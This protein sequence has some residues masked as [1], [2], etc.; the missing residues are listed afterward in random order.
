T[1]DVARLRGALGQL[2][3][4]VAAL[5]QVG[6][7]HRDIKPSNVL[8]TTAAR[9]VLVDF[10]LVIDAI[11]ERPRVSME[12]IVGTAAYMAPEQAASARLTPASAWY[13]VGGMLYEALTGRLPSEGSALEIMMRKQQEE[14]A[15]PHP[16]APDVPADLD[17][18]CV[19]LM[20]RR[21]EDRPT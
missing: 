8:V 12:S 17:A 3:Q 15:P 14:P 13:A 7:L 11:P 1:L 20:R 4:G 21:P 2:A 5:H 18:L 6:K 9:V 10:G 19:D 16:R